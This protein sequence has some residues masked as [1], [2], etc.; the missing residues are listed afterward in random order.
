MF[1]A[2][3]NARKHSLYQLVTY[4]IEMNHMLSIEFLQFS[5]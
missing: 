1:P 4:C 5:I 3:D 2:I